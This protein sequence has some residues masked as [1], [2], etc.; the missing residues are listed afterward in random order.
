MDSVARPVWQDTCNN[1]VAPVGSIAGGPAPPTTR[2]PTTSQ[3]AS[4]CLRQQGEN[5]TQAAAMRACCVMYTFS[6]SAT[7]HRDKPTKH[8]ETFGNTTRICHKDG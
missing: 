7:H 5:G 8:V 2:M 1:L 3:C 4:P 6:S